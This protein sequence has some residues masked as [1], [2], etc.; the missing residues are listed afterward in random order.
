MSEYRGR[1]FVPVLAP[2][3]SEALTLSPVAHPIAQLWTHIRS[4]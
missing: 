2:Y 3:R 4:Y 1:V